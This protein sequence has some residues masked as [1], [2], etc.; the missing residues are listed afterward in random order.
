MKTEQHPTEEQL[1]LYHYGEA[2]ERATVEA[3]LAACD[4]CGAGYQALGRVLA[5]VA[6]APLPERAD[7]YGSQVWE[8][9]R[10]RL[11]ERPASRWAG[12]LSAV[13]SLAVRSR[14][15]A[16]VLAEQARALDKLTRRYEEELARAEGE[17]M[18]A[19]DKLARRIEEQMAQA[20]GEPARAL[21]K[22]VH[23]GYGTLYDETLAWAWPPQPPLPAEPPPSA[24]PPLP[25]WPAPPAEPPPPAW[26]APPAAQAPA[27]APAP[28][29]MPGPAIAPAPPGALFKGREEGLYQRAMRALDERHWEHAVEGFSEVARQGGSRA[30]GALYWKAYAQNRLGRRADALATLEELRKTYPQSRWLNDAKALEVEVRQASG[31]AVAPESETDDELKLLAINSL[32]HSDAERAVPL[33]EKLLAGNHAPKLK[34]RA[35]FVLSQSGSPRARE[36]V[37]QLARGKSNPDLQM[38]AVQYLGMYGG[39]ESRQMLAEIYR[40]STDLDIKRKILQSFMIARERDLLLAAAKG[41]TVPELRREAIQQLGVLGAQA[42]LW[43]LYGTE[44]SVEVKER[45][46]HSLF[47]G[48]NIEKLIEVAR[49]EK[50]SRLR[51]AAIHHLGIVSRESGDALVSI[52][53]GES[54]PEIRKAVINSLFIQRNAKALVDIARKETDPALRREIVQKLSVMKSKEATDFLIELLNK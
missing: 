53:A 17:Q 25:A 4:A 18:G 11:A 26:P 23:R 50:E 42:E 31:Q 44:T 30:D 7:S 49:T 3:H 46:L 8:R 16:A 37:A 2:G 9:L 38:K 47:I 6:A 29:A 36:V 13:G 5:A 15:W 32:M 39:K 24:E 19:S 41:E 28:P 35:L 54:D 20:A 43:Q 48:K 34:E 12:F 10:P 21:D 1:I 40:S 33:L 45:I 14:R 51:R 22:L 27:P 52:Y